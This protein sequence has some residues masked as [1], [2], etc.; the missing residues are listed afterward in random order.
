[1]R[2][3]SRFLWVAV[4]FTLLYSGYII[5]QRNS[6][7]EGPK[8]NRPTGPDPTEAYGKKVKI[9][10]FYATPSVIMPGEKSLLCYGVANAP[11]VKLDPPV[12]KVWESI[13]RCFNVSP[14]KTT[15]YTLNAEG[16]DHATA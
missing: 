5:W 1:M 9:L 8:K 16:A 3:I 10:T 4:I 14:T 13:S 2:T 11:V 15:R 7:W 6:S 12:E